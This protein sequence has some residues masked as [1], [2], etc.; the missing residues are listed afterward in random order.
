M[1]YIDGRKNKYSLSVCF[2]GYVDF[3]VL[4]LIVVPPPPG[5]NSLA[6]QLNNNSNSI[7]F[8]SIYLCAKLNSPEA[9]YKASTGKK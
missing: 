5:N 9:N 8:N 2:V 4:C 7:K 1:C 3:C 6:V